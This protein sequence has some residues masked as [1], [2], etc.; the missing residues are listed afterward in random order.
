PARKPKIAF[1]AAGLAA[2]SAALAIGQALAPNALR[3]FLESF[4]AAASGLSY[5]HP[6]RWAHVPR[7]LKESPPLV[8]AALAGLSVA[9]SRTLSENER[10][11]LAFAHLNWLAML[12]HPEKLPFYLASLAPFLMLAL[13]A[14]WRAL[15]DR[16]PT[17]AGPRIGIGL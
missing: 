14:A 4:G 17:L 16:H 9:R 2:V 5:W 3:F 11:L 10:A 1:L 13:P 6:G 12:P 15:V 8:L 7:F